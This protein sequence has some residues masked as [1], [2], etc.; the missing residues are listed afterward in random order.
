MRT[1]G[2]TFAIATALALGLTA[3]GGGDDS[4][5]AGGEA[6]TSVTLEATDELAFEPDSINVAADEEVEVTL[7]CGPNV[8]HN[9]LIE[10]H[11]GEEVIADCAAG[12]SD[13]GTFTVE[14]GDHTFYCNIPGHRE[15]GM[16]GTLTAS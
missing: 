9:F 3:C 5:D 12:E 10:G 7:D 14:A 4:G 15:A 16:E 6:A 2:R 1:P 8:E 11:E 13:S